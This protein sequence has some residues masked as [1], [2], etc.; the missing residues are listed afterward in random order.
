M[1]FTH[2]F[3]IL[4]RLKQSRT[5]ARTLEQK[6]HILHMTPPASFKKVEDCS[7]GAHVRDLTRPNSGLNAPYARVVFHSS[8]HSRL[9][10]R[11]VPGTQRTETHSVAVHALGQ[12]VVREAS[13]KKVSSEDGCV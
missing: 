5:N 10:D 8:V 1:G 11:R 3:R 13:E 6:T 12:L 2:A 4:V 7:A 9:F